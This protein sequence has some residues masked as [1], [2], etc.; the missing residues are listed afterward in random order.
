MLIFILYL[1]FLIKVRIGG[2]LPIG[3]SLGLDKR[4]GLGLWMRRHLELGLGLWL[5]L[6]WFWQDISFNIL[7][8]LS[9]FIYF[10]LAY[11]CSLFGRLWNTSCGKINRS[12]C[13]FIWWIDSLWWLGIP[14]RTQTWSGIKRCRLLLADLLHPRVLAVFDVLHHNSFLIFEKN[15]FF[16]DEGNFLFN[17]FVLCR[18]LTKL[19]SSCLYTLQLRSLSKLDHGGILNF[20][21][22]YSCLNLKCLK[23][24]LVLCAYISGYVLYCFPFSFT[25][26]FW[27]DFL[28]FCFLLFSVMIDARNWT[29]F[30]FPSLG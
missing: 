2:D 9:D 3:L 26:T 23:Y 1:R 29:F 25:T 27:I 21:L 7:L 19:S 11:R 8:L 17:T 18:L 14:I 13:C 4:L 22:R 30:W 6:L 16:I 15:R 5:W 12:F 10:H 24:L 28:D 20:S